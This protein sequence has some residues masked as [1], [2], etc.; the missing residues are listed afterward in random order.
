MREVDDLLLMTNLYP[1]STGLPMVIWV[2]PSYGTHHDVRIEVM[3][4]HGTRMYPCTRTTSPSSL[5]VRH[6]GLS[7]DICRQP[8]C[9]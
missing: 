3:M 2:A 9:G 7:R 8:I 1:A 4:A 5:F 6:R